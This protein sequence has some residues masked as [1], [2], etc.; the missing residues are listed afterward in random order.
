MS[1]EAIPEPAVTIH[2]LTGFQ[3]DLLIALGRHE[4]LH[5]HYPHGL[6]IKDQIS[7]RYDEEIHHGRLYPNLDALV[8]LDL[9]EKSERDK[10]TNAYA[11]TPEGSY[12]LRTYA[13]WLTTSLNG[14]EA[15]D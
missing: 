14:G 2:D 7:E 6:A 1:I 4:A 5:N 9:V 10:R 13:Q 3:R 12:V 11:L 8:D 15:D